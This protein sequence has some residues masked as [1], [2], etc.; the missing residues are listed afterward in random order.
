MT[1]RASASQHTVRANDDLSRYFELLKLT[2]SGAIYEESAWRVLEPDKRPGLR[3][4]IRSAILR[5]LQRRGLAV[6]YQRAYDAKQREFG[7]DWPMVGLT[8]V[9]HRRLD[10]VRNCILTVIADG[11][12]GDF[13]ECGVWRGGASI[14]AKALLD[15]YGA[16][17]RRVWLADSFEGMPAIEAEEDKIDID[18]SEVRYLAVTQDQVAA[19]FKRFGLLDE[20]VRFIKGWFSESLSSAP[21]DAIAVLR[22]DGDHYTSTMASL[23]SLYGK[24][25]PGGFVIIDDYNVFAGCKRAVTEFRAAHGISAELV[26]IDEDAVYWRR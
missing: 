9:G 19:N 18:L 26:P 6:V 1:V 13:V 21:I 5:A 24:V 2:L 7:Q 10:N 11:I 20:N 23:T 3:G 22:L 4:R 15:A 16:N 12:P 8:M 14:Y 17:D 25:S